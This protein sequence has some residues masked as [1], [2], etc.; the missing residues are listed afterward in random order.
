MEPELWNLHGEGLHQPSQHFSASI[1]WQYS[2][3]VKNTRLIFG[4]PYEE[5]D[6]TYVS[7]RVPFLVGVRVSTKLA[8]SVLTT[9]SAN[10]FHH[11]C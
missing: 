9:A 4:K 7:L 1:A 6:S 10:P 8:L 3:E 11:E 5:P 2:E